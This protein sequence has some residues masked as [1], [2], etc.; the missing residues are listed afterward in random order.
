MSEQGAIDA[1]IDALYPYLGHFEI[2]A[3]GPVFEISVRVLPGDGGRSITL[4]CETD[5]PV[6][7]A[8]DLLTDAVGWINRQPNTRPIAIATDALADEVAGSLHALVASLVG[9]VSWSWPADTGAALARAREA[10]KRW[11]GLS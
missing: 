11:E 1:L 9:H 4:S 10:L 3:V 5:D 7:G 6:T 8:R 2:R